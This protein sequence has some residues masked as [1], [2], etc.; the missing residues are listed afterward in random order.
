MLKV[1]ET[2]LLFLFATMLSAAPASDGKR[3]WSFVEFLAS[4]QLEG[5]NTGSEGHRKA[6]EYVAAQFERDGLRPAGVQGYIQPVKFDTLQL[7]EAGSSL[8]L[9]RG[10]KATP[11]ALGDEA[12]I[13][14]RN[15]PEPSVEAP[16]VFVGHGL[17]I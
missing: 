2:A 4:D 15:Y 9:I 8:A 16:L 14:A 6:A 17:R 13:G 11:I 10:D 3:W 12:I 5:R 7:D 1:R